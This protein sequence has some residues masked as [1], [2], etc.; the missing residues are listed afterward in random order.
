MDIFSTEFRS[1]NMAQIRSTGSRPELQL[2]SMI[3]LLLA[4]MSPA[5]RRVVCNATQ[6]LGSPDVYVPSLSLAVF[7]DGCFFH[8][9]PKHGRAPKTNTEYWE[10]KIA[11]NQRRDSRIS[12]LLRA[13]GI[14]VWRFWEHEFR[15]GKLDT[16]ERRMERAIGKA[17]HRHRLGAPAQTTLHNDELRLD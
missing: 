10:S 4:E 15:H 7:V 11:R 5:R 14:S 12:R 8:G 1:H 17:I 2:R 6:I 3:R 16:T 13:K 9:C